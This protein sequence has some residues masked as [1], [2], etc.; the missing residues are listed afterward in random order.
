MNRW[1]GGKSGQIAAERFFHNKNVSLSDIVSW[2]GEGCSERSSSGHVLV[3]HD[4]TEFNYNNLNGLLKVNDPD[5]GVISD[6]KSTGFFV[7][8]A[9]AIDASNGLP[10]GLS[11]VDIWSRRFGHADKAERE[12]KKLPIEEKE[13]YKWIKAAE[14]SKHRLADAERITLIG[15]REND[16]YE[17][18]CKTIDKQTDI[19]IRSSKDRKVD[20]GLRLSQHLSKLGWYGLASLEIKHNKKRIARQAYLSLRWS[21]VSINKPANKKQVLTAYPA[22]QTVYVVELQEQAES[23][24]VGEKPIHWRLLTTHPVNNIEDALQ[25][26]QWYANR[27]WIEDLFRTVKKQGL[28]VEASQFGRGIALKKLVLVCLEEARKILLLRQA[29]KDCEHIPADM[30][31]TTQQQDCLE[32]IQIQVEGKTEKQKNPYVK[33]TLSWASWIIARLGGWK[34]ADMNKRP[35]GV[36]SMARGLKKFN[37][38][39]K[40]WENAHK[41]FSKLYNNS[42]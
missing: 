26:A 15:D 6:D 36:L 33:R 17:Y 10:F 38:Q 11:S 32:A 20:N 35:P 37:Q 27:W 42:P 28:D 34:P 14:Q 5:V 30:C 39:Y 3:L 21:K 12:Y 1:S 9:L 13:S 29:R 19:L 31:F 4:T 41:L 22:K 8:A 23:V 18:L 7:H 24:P 40:G 2:I 16:I 25:I